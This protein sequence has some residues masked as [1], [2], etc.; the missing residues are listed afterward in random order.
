VAAFKPEVAVVECEDADHLQGGEDDWQFV[1][2]GDQSFGIK[3]A[4]LEDKAAACQMLVTY[5]RE[6]KG[7]NIDYVEQTTQLMVPLL[8]FYFHDGVRTSAAEALPELLEAAKVKGPEFVAGMWRF[9]FRDLLKATEF[10]PENDVLSEMLFSLAKC[11]ECLGAGCLTDKDLQDIV[12]VLD[13]HMV[14]HFEKAAERDELR[15]DEDYDEE[16]EKDLVDEHDEDTW[17]LSKVSDVLHAGT[18]KEA[19]VPYFE[20]LLPHLIKLLEPNRPYPDYQWALCIFDDLIEFGGLS[21]LKYQQY[22]LAPMVRALEHQSPE[23]RQ[24]AAY[25]FG[26]MG[27][28][29][30]T[31][32]AQACAEA[33]P[34][35]AK[36]IDAPDSRGT[37]ANLA[38]TENAIAAVA[39][40]L[41]Y[42]NSLVDVGRVLPA[43]IGWL[44][45]WEDKEE[46]PHIYGYLCDVIESNN[47]LVMGENGANVPHLIA[48]I[49]EAFRQ[50]AFEE[51]S[52]ENPVS[53][54]MRTILKHVQAN[55]LVFQASLAI[56]NDEQKMI[57]QRELMTE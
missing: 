25:G 56:L 19:V 2:L 46:C 27:M 6:L 45:V 5:A 13:R 48:I 3:T 39:K 49:V 28:H 1:N 7:G 8:K 4:G 31:G 38:A 33:I 53:H 26:I 24:A 11:V 35:L 16:L 23:V 32:Y 36:L 37:E 10:E 55:E 20:K 34:Y 44:P 18:H 9:I 50:S 42:N 17:L 57:L 43:F 14:K 15:R 52:K 54:R 29:G 12:D 21:S 30:G 40:I 41:K 47:P 51:E 22:F